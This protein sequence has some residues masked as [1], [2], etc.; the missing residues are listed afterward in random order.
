MDQVKTAMDEIE[1]MMI[2]E[3]QKLRPT[4]Q[5][6]PVPGET[7]MERLHRIEQKADHLAERISTVLRHLGFE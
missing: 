4:L 3:T 1:G 7:V 2:R 5:M 6:R